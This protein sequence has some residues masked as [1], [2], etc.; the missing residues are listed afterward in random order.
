MTPTHPFLE[1]GNINPPFAI[2]IERHDVKPNGD[3]R[4]VAH[5]RFGLELRTSGLLSALSPEDL[6][7]LFWVLSFVTSNGDCNPILPRLA[8]AMNVTTG[9]AQVRLERLIQP[10][11]QSQ[12]LLL[13]TRVGD[14]LAFSPSPA[15]V[16]TRYEEPPQSAPSPPLP[17][18]SPRSREETVAHS[19]SRYARPRAEVE[20]EIARLNGWPE[21]PFEVDA[22]NTVGEVKPANSSS[23]DVQE[24]GIVKDQLL[25]VGLNEEQADDLLNRFDSLRIRRQLSWLNYHPH[26][27]NRAG[28]LIAAIEDNYA[29]PPIL[30]FR[31]PDES[32]L[33]PQTG[34]EQS[35]EQVPDERL[36]DVMD[37]S[38]VPPL[39]VSDLFK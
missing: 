24:Q 5:V 25:R 34:V 32:S 10:L 36:L 3:F 30:R 20:R 27:R 12:P 39:D 16:S 7:T 11:W 35:P 26:V 17:A 9:K 2:V 6:K 15:V 18:S 23:P 29:A 8:E 19:R 14:Q 4:P 33:S 13:A 1:D 28:F 31:T 38:D 22:P 37:T 21:P